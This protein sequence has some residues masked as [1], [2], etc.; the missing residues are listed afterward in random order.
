MEFSKIYQLHKFLANRRYPARL[1]DILA[2]LEWSESTF[3][4]VRQYMVDFLG[5]PIINQR[6]QGYHYDLKADEHYELPGLWFTS[7]E[8]IALGVLEQLSE[9]FQPDV[10]KPLLEPVAERLSQLLKKQNLPDSYWSSRI[11]VVSQWQRFC[12]PEFFS[13]IAQALLERRRIVIDY[14]DWQR[15]QTQQRT[16]S[17]QRLVYYRDNWYLD[18][19]CHLR[20]AHRIFAVD[21]IRQVERTDEPVKEVPPSELDKHVKGGYG[22]FAGKSQNWAQ[23]KFSSQIARR[24]SRELWHPQQKR[25]WTD[26]GELLLS[27]PYSDHREL[28]R[29]ILHYGSDVEVLEPA[30]LRQIVHQEIEEMLKKY[31]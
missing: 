30:S 29:D 6:G 28:L 27:I 5:A 9:S 31:S 20:D 15:D 11:K 7:R 13:H 23:L 21:A 10:V 8:I 3:F 1:E 18:A 12:E 17:P 22:I 19:W 16:I 14:W 26:D 24:T 25:I 2:Q 4:R